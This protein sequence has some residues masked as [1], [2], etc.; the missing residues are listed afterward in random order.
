[1]C[2]SLCCEGHNGKHLL[3]LLQPRLPAL[4]CP[5]SGNAHGLD[6]SLPRPLQPSWVLFWFRATVLQRW[7]VWVA[8]LRK[9]WK[10]LSLILGLRGPT[11]ILFISRDALSNSIAILC[12]ACFPWVAHRSLRAQRLK[13]N[14]SRLKFS[15]P[16]EYFNPDWKFQSWPSEFPTK[17]RGLLGGSL[18]IFNLDWKFQS[19]RSILNLFNLWALRGITRYVAEWG[20]ALMCL[21]CF[22]AVG[23]VLSWL[24]KYRAIG[25]I[26]AILSQYRAIR[27]QQVLGW[28][29]DGKL[30]QERHPGQILVL[31]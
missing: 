11:A 17:K 22:C 29:H 30:L 15:I 10:P 24:K 13:K 5:A 2:N 21:W 26:A 12:H 1:M 25:S 18:E 9:L 23:W 14:Q 28:Y 16:I 8:V 7:P 31:Y 19:R 20:I 4:N 3:S 27:G 6:I